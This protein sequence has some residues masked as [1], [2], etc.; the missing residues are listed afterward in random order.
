[1]VKRDGARGRRPPRGKVRSNGLCDACPA[2]C[3]HTLLVPFKKP[4]TRSEIDF[5]KWHVQYDTVRIAIHLRRWYLVI[6]G[7]CIYLSD[8]DL[9]SV[10]DHRP[11]TCRAHNPPE[12]EHYGDWYQVMINTPEELGA[13]FEAEQRRRRRR[14]LRG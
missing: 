1:M 11:D 5:Y 9:C 4:R 10:Y 13:Y 7:R 2:K 12:C 6:A 8:G 14:R 3:C